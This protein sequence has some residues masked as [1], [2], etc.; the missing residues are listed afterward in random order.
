MLMLRGAAGA[1]F[2]GGSW[3][4]ARKGVRNRAATIQKR[5]RIKHLREG[6][7]LTAGEQFRQGEGGKGKISKRR[8]RPLC[9]PCVCAGKRAAARLRPCKATITSSWWVWVR[10]MTVARD[11]RARGRL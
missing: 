1:G 4:W 2:G 7:E 5:N 11:A 3:A 10:A 8:T 6:M 9:A